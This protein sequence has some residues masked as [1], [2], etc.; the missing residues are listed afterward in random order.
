DNTWTLQVPDDNILP[1]G[2]Y[3]VVVTVTDTDTDG[4]IANDDTTNELSIE[5]IPVS[6]ITISK[7]VDNI[8]PLVGDYIEFTIRV[9]NSGETEF[10]DVVIDEVIASG[11]TYQQH[12]ASEGN[13]IPSNGVW[14]IP[15]L[16]P[17]QTVNLSIKVQV[18]PT[19]NHSNV[20]T[21]I[22]TNPT[23]DNISNNTSEVI[24]ELSCLTVFNEFTPNNDGYNDFFR[25][26]CIEQYPNNVLKIFNRYGNK[27][28]ETTG[29]LNNWSGIAN[30]N[31][32]VDRGKQLPA[33]V[34]FYSLQID[35]LG[36]DIS[37]WLY[38][39]K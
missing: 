12:S 27:V 14:N 4:N 15:S 17:N 11:F 24:I 7:T 6:D 3:D 39:A 9:I 23:D 16:M 13:Y 20:A 37:G 31:G 5:S 30:V 38:I 28:F 33:G 36:E 29:Y 34:Y 32:A 21:I 25:I 22:S 26:E 35:E 8:N 10:K 19:G 1:D 2:V 18:N